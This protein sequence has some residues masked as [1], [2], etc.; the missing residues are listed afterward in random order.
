MRTVLLLFLFLASCTQSENKIQSKTY[1]DLAGLINQ[2][3]SDLSAKKP[4]VEKTVVLAHKQE[5]I[6]TKDIDWNK[7][8]ELFLQ[9]DLNKQSYQSGYTIDTKDKRV[10]YQLKAGEKLS[11]TQLLIEF[12]EKDLPKHIEATMHTNNY[13]YES[14]K[15]LTADL[16][17]NQLKSYKIEGYKELFIGSRKNFSVEGKI[18]N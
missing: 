8:L 4:L 18:K 12:D 17:N 16:V 15:K 9:A 14:D 1:Y 2:Q 3:I 6:E 13:L 7:E 5:R 11:V 10:S